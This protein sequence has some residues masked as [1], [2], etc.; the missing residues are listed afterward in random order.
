M[1]HLFLIVLTTLALTSPVSAQ[2]LGKGLFDLSDSV[3]KPAQ[4]AETK[5]TAVLAPAKE[6]GVVL[7]QINLVLPE[8]VNTYSMD[9][10]LPKPTKITVDLPDGWTSLEKGFRS[11]PLPKKSFDEAFGKELEKYYGEVTFFKRIQVPAGAKLEAAELEGK[12]SF[13]TCDAGSCTPQ[14]ASFKAKFDAKAKP[15]VKGELAEAEEVTPA[16]ESPAAVA[17]VEVQVAPLTAGYVVVPTRETRDGTVADPVSLQFELSPANPKAGDVVTL[18]ITMTIA[19]GW[20]TYGLVKANE[21]QIEKPTV[22]NFSVENL[23]AVGGLVSVPEPVLHSTKI[24]DELLHSNAHEQQVTWLQKFNA[25]GDVAPG[26]I[27][28]IQYQICQTGKACMSVKSVEFSLGTNQKSTD[29]LAA[30]PIVKSFIS[31]GV[32]PTEERDVMSRLKVATVA[33]GDFTLLSAFASAFFA[34][35]LMNILPCVLPVLAIK[36]LSLVQQ[37]GE[38]RFRILALNLTY[39]A[40]VLIVFFGFAVLSWG[41]GQSMASVFQNQTFMIVMACV[42]FLMGLSLFGVFELPVPGIIPSAGHHQEGYI[43]AFNTGIIATLLGTPCIGPFIAPVFTWCLTQPPATVFTLFGMMGIG[44]ASPFLLTGVFPSLVKWLPRPGDWMVKFKQFTGFVL[45]GTVIWLLVTIKIEW[46]VPVL[47]LLLSL[48]MMVWMAANFAASYDPVWKQ[49][50]AYL[51][52]FLASAPVFCFGLW[53]MEEFRPL[54]A[55]EMHVSKMPWQNFSEDQLIRLREEGRPMLIDFTADWCVICKL[56]EK[57]AMDRVETVKFV[58]E[59][60]IVPMMADF[61]EENPEILKWLRQ[62]GTESVPLTIIIP[63]GKDSDI[64]VMGGQFT[65]S[66]LLEKLRQAVGSPLEDKSD[67]V[68]PSTA[69]VQ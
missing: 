42:V 31:H 41:L 55:N 27:G 37:A 4:Q 16:V 56:N 13:L 39:T 26:V 69:M 54:S 60:G 68:A 11:D 47:V 58:K 7:L 45:M 44:M 52:S 40:G 53:L 20:S 14:N 49:R 17:P 62:F 19:D 65:Q 2:G 8:G 57:V 33:A 1:R 64:I 5:V 18:A 36:I 51:L 66:M 24:G 3:A 43:G 23:V 15:A 25:V 22:I 10:E 48:G 6:A 12:I 50:R 67:R 9:P 21:E 61:T 38:S 30:Q 28:T 59:N 32:S 35:L 46:R 34:G 29:I 63:P